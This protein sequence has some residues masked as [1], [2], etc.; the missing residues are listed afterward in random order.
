MLNEAL[1]LLVKTTQ[2]P[3]FCV[4]QLE[5]NKSE[6]IQNQI[7]YPICAMLIGCEG[8]MDATGQLH[9]A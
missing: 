9:T 3:L 6:S 8:S 7:V 5:L 2:E 4:P 1:H